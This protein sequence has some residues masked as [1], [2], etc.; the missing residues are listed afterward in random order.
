MRRNEN[1]VRGLVAVALLISLVAGC[2]GTGVSGRRPRSQRRDGRSTAREA[3]VRKETEDPA[4]SRLEAARIE[5]SAALDGSST[6]LRPIP[7]VN[8]AEPDDD[9]PVLPAKAIMSGLVSPNFEVIRTICEKGP[10]TTEDWERM[11]TSA[12]L[13]AEASRL[14]EK[15]APTDDDAW[16]IAASGMLRSGSRELI[17]A[18]TRGDIAA[19]RSAYRKTG[20][21]CG[22]C[23]EDCSADFLPIE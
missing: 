22:T 8:V 21:A 23:H 5:P 13:L 10:Q 11:T 3:I 19:A 17:A 18:A 16:K 4:T 1:V 6:A 2:V 15:A 14:L 9:I 20:Q 12:T 7:T